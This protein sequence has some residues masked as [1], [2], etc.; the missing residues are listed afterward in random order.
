MKSNRWLWLISLLFLHSEIASSA[1]CSS[2]N[3]ADSVARPIINIEH[4]KPTRPA[5]A[6]SV[7]RIQAPG[8]SK[9]IS[10]AVIPPTAMATAT[11]TAT[12]TAAAS[13][14]APSDVQTVAPA[15][16]IVA[17]TSAAEPT[18]SSQPSQH[19]CESC[20]IHA[21][22]LGS[23]K[24][25][26]IA[27]RDFLTHLNASKDK[28][29]VWTRFS[30]GELLAI[31][32]MDEKERNKRALPVGEITQ[33]A[34]EEYVIIVYSKNHKRFGCLEKK[35]SEAYR[36]VYEA[37]PPSSW[38]ASLAVAE[39]LGDR[40]LF[41]ALGKLL[42]SIGFAETTPV[43]IAASSSAA[44]SMIER[45]C[46]HCLACM[47][48]P[49]VGVTTPIGWRDLVTHIN[50]TKNKLH[51]WPRS[52]LKEL[53]KTIN[54]VE[55]VDAQMR[56]EWD[57]AGRHE[58]S[59]IAYSR[60]YKKFAYLEKRGHVALWIRYEADPPSDWIKKLDAE[61][62][63]RKLRRVIRKLLASYDP[64]IE[65][66]AAPSFSR[67]HLMPTSVQGHALSF[68][69]VRSYIRFCRVSHACYQLSLQPFRGK[70]EYFNF[71]ERSADDFE[72]FW[73]L[74]KKRL[75]SLPLTDGP[76]EEHKRGL[77][78]KLLNVGPAIVEALSSDMAPHLISLHLKI[79]LELGDT[80]R[81]GNA[82]TVFPRLAELLPS[83][84]G[85]R[86]F[87]LGGSIY[88][89]IGTIA[90]F[91]GSLPE[92]T[93]LRLATLSLRRTALA[94]SD[95]DK[96]GAALAPFTGLEYLDLSENPP[97]DSICIVQLS[98]NLRAGMKIKCTPFSV[99]D[100]SGLSCALP[101]LIEL[102]LVP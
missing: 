72:M 31:A 4:P 49:S 43:D 57:V 93:K 14:G 29:R 13:A 58:Y 90:F 70:C 97:F 59:I 12:A 9:A 47:V 64:A 66:K 54:E 32:G 73:S 11:A 15:S 38:M 92:H 51:V 25:I 23:D 89:D 102:G 50:A 8:E 94:N 79:D 2:C 75:K 81:S 40:D 99:I 34:N 26:F 46:A 52:S 63:D 36:W 62:N 83:A 74:A 98:K 18:P 1:V 37:S 65:E 17:T 100:G 86:H 19:H 53:L 60:H 69:S 56:A 39:A 71:Q 78:L 7:E 91:L 3:T 24:C 61:K 45:P 21:A 101:K 30:I 88:L 76:V 67:W 42:A 35:S 27:W 82:L 77:E 41:K 10:S 48:Y 84:T 5:A 80:Y 96:L 85:L 44:A 87:D 68:L 20:R 55:P 6:P 33:D 22:D 95:V 16:S 28:L